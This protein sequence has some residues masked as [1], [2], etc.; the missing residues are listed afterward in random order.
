MQKHLASIFALAL[1]LGAVFT[2]SVRAQTTTFTYQG[3]LTDG[4]GVANAIYDMQFKLF[5]AAANGNQVG[6]TLTNATVQVANGIFTLPLDF[7]AAAFPGADRFVEV[8]VRPAGSGNAYNTLSPRQ[9]VTSTPYAVQALN[10]FTATT[11]ANLTTA[12][13][14]NFIQ[15]TATQQAA[16]NFNISG[17]GTVG[18]TLTANSVNAATQFNLGNVRIL[19]NAG[20]NNLFEGV[21]AGAANTT[22]IGNTFVGAGAG[23]NNGS[24]D[25]NNRAF[26]NTFVGSRAGNSNT[27]G[28]ENSFFGAAAGQANLVGDLN[29]FFGSSAGANNS[30]G[31][32]NS[33]FGAGAG[34]FNTG[35][36]SNSFFGSGA[37][38][39]TTNGSGNSFFGSGAGNN[40]TAG[41]N[42]TL[43]GESA[44][45]PAGSNLNFATAIG[46]GAF[47]TASNSIVLGRTTGATLDNVGIGVAAPT[48]KLHV[49][50]TGAAGLRVQTN[51]SG[52]TVASFGGNGDFQVDAPNVPGGRFIVQQN[53]NVGIGT[54]TPQAKLDVN[55]IIRVAAFGTAGSTQLCV[56]SLNQIS[57]CGS[58]LRYKTRIAPFSTGLQLIKQLQPITFDWKLGGMHDVGFGAE[59]V[60]RLNPLFVTYNQKGQVEGVKYDRFSTLFVNAFKEQ[61][62]QIEAQQQLISAQ[63]S[64]IEQQQAAIDTQHAQTTVNT[65]KLETQ[66]D[67]QQQQLARQQRMIHGLRIL[68][69]HT[70][71]HASVCK[72]KS[73]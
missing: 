49:I 28:Q 13:S 37:G 53:G 63:Q 67:S 4:G 52:G 61:Q 33:F 65:Q 25:T 54:A 48:F 1:L 16:A 9:Q 15:N 29:S 30:T 39:N 44:D 57:S 27:T 42:N 24:G 59:D 14:A 58:S 31:V 3:K 51:T 41:S 19:S 26:K 73:G 2:G 38:A 50:D 70:N 11:A 18:G 47:V 60:A 12:G 17:N 56:N 34:L 7:G 35:G 36:I 8:S 69:C 72:K 71:S 66:L 45:V 10:A 68:A 55:G 64:E 20:T 43:I 46:A 6:A 40:N 32:G 22:E 21:D 62:G 5:D 23:Q